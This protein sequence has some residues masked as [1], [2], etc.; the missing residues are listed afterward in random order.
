MNIQHNEKLRDR[1]AAE[2][3]LGTLKG[4]ARRRFEYWLKN[5]FML[6]QAVTEWQERLSPLS[7][8]APPV[9]P[10]QQVWNRINQRI[11]SQVKKDA[12]SARQIGRAHV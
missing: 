12:P 9:Q 7:E 10:P 1:L 8:F 2:Y 6:R 5:D 3:V 4:G 11:E